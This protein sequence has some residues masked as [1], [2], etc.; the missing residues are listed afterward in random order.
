MFIALGSVQIAI[1]ALTI[2]L[3][4]FHSLRLSALGLTS[5][6]LDRRPGSL[7]GLLRMSVEIRANN[8]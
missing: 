8:D 7:G 5:L 1:C 4:K 6:Y 2:P 3:C